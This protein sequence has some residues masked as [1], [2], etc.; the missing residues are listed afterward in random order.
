MRKRLLSLI[1]MVTMICMIVYKVPAEAAT[2]SAYS[3]N[4]SIEYS[5]S[6]TVSC[7]TIRYISQNAGDSYFN[8]SY[9]PTSS[10]GGYSGP[11]IECGT[12]CMSMALSYIGINQTPKTLLEATNGYTMFQGYDG[13]SCVSH[14]SS[15]IT[16]AMSNYIGGNGKYSPPMIHIPGYSS[17]G[18]FVLVIGQIS[19]TQYQILDPASCSVTEMTI[20]GSSATYVKNGTTISDTIDRMYQW[21]N[22]NAAISTDAA[23]V[24][25][26]VS[27]S[28]LSS[29]GYTVTCT[30]T[31]DVAVD[32]VQFPSWS[33]N[34]GQDDLDL[35]WIGSQACRG[36]Q[37]GNTF[38]YYVSVSDHNN[39]SGKYFTHIYAYDTAGNSSVYHVN[40]IMVP[41][42]KNFQLT[43]YDSTGAVWLTDTVTENT[44]HTLSAS[45]PTKSGSYF[46]GWSFAEGASD[47][48]VR[49]SGTVWVTGNINLYPVYVTHEEAVSGE[50]VFIY[51]INDFTTSG[52]DIKEEQSSTP[53]YIDNSYWTE[54]SGYGTDVIA[55]SDT[56]QVRTAPLYRYYYYLCP[57]CGEHEPFYGKSDCG[58]QIPNTAVYTGWFTTP[59]S[60]CNYKTFSYTTAK[61]YTNSLSDGQVW[62]FSSG[63][64]NDTAIGTIDADS[65]A[66]VITTGYSSRSYVEQISTSYETRTGYIITEQVPVVLSSVTIST[67]PAKL[68]Y[69][70]GEELDTS[71]MVITAAYSDGTTN[72]I[73]EG[74]TVSGFDSSV[75]GTQ[76]IT[77][78]YGDMSTS[79]TVTVSEPKEEVDAEAPQ[80]VVESKSALPGETITVTISV[81]N[82]PG[83]ASM[84]LKVAYDEIL[85]LNSITYNSEIGGQ[86]QQPQSMSSPI[87]LNWFNGAGDSEGDWVFATLTFEVSEE[88]QEGD[89]AEIS[90]SYDLLDLYNIAEESIS[91][92]VVNGTVE[93][94]DY[95]PGDINND[96]VV[97]NRDLTRLFQYL[98]DWDVEV[99]ERA[100]DVNGDGNVN[101]RDLTRLFQYL[102]D[103][104]V[105]IY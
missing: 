89:A 88:A 83:I 66:V 55:A 79:F 53:H 22:A 9:W 100:I 29:A 1:I 2:Q 105:E 81:K 76:T 67:Y 30:V 7:G 20:N 36:T 98:S 43:Y 52:Y 16:T 102:S 103:W 10:F 94:S 65:D 99:N 21:Y 32:R 82:N 34:N 47:Y 44:T 15:G 45:Y 3:P 31:D 49:P 93:I 26:D 57:S 73:T 28:N 97:N 74:F 68:T 96:G 69:E 77:I 39:D 33:D 8:W 38:T 78:S 72:T 80:I 24:I 75:A 42:V 64:V 63:N 70:Q 48:S 40:D 85:T 12:A 92:S 101:N 87:T 46:C 71:G 50:M 18:H 90:V 84:K 25:S 51:N 62:I 37:N 19:G 86:S 5:Y 14:S 56:V 104:D 27:V 54:W 4:P 58:A 17:A 23:P 59:Y 61:Y 91:F 35:N 41:E 11:G 6:S 95:L 60:Q 13:S